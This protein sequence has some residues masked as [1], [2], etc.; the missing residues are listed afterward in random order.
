MIGLDMM[1]AQALRKR[2]LELMA[3][4]TKLAVKRTGLIVALLLALGIG[5]GQGQAPAPD[6]SKPAMPHRIHLILKDGGYQIVTSYSVVGSIVRYVSAERGGAVEEIPVELVDLE[7]TER[8]VKKH[9]PVDEGDQGPGRAPALD[10]ELLKE[11]EERA[12]LTPEI[13]PDLRLPQED[14]LLVL[15][16]FQGEPELVPLVQTDGDLNHTTSHSVL[17]KVL[18]PRAAPHQL[19]TLRGTKS[20]VQLHV[21]DPVFYVRL[22]D[23]TDAPAGGTPLVV[24]THGASGAAGNQEKSTA[25][26]R[27]VVVQ[28][29]VRVDA[30]VIASFDASGNRET[31]DAIETQTDVL[32]GGHWMKVKPA[33]QL[34]IGEYALVEVLSDKEINLGVWDFGVHPV[35]PENRDVIKPQ[36]KRRSDLERRRPD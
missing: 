13:E 25:Q 8:W 36:P 11:E 14:S 9:A 35:S 20:Y 1:T 19:L 33:R 34:E 10:P 18:N 30:R 31:G 32:R 2:S 29:D 12:S 4:E 5:I 27:Y 24:D 3:A 21:N 15:D 22:G 17:K 6:A 7:A 16:E 23:G 28:A 26:S